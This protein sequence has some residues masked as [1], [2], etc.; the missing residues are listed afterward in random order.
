MSEFIS[1]E[2]GYSKAGAL[3]VVGIAATVGVAAIGMQFVGN[4]E[5][6]SPERGA[7]ADEPPTPAEPAFTGETL[8]GDNSTIAV[9]DAMGLYN[10]GGK[11]NETWEGK[12]FTPNHL[13]AHM[14][15]NEELR[16]SDRDFWVGLQ[17]TAAFEFAVTNAL[18]NKDADPNMEI[19]GEP[20]Y[21]EFLRKQIPMEG[22]A[23]AIADNHRCADTDNDK[24]PDTVQ[25][26]DFRKTKNATYTGLIL[27]KANFEKWQELVEE[28]G[29]EADR[30]IVT[31]FTH[32]L[33]G[34]G[35]D[36]DKEDYVHITN[37]HM[38]CA[39]NAT[40]VRVPEKTPGTTVTTAPPKLPPITIVIPT[41]TTTEKPTTTT[42]EKSTT[43]TT[44][45][46]TTTTYPH[47]TTTT[48]PKRPT[49]TPD[50]RPGSTTSTTQPYPTGTAGG[51]GTT[52]TTTEARHPSTTTTVAQDNGTPENPN[53]EFNG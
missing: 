46:T 3:T 18:A 15:A 27:T 26:H 5:S 50:P 7:G 47:Y 41:T 13:L 10:C 8:N 38:I 32:D 39:N 52:T 33:D 48:I 14:D 30:F 36:F 28:S 22:V 34:E 51:P 9:E 20:V 19:E 23:A 17:G 1:G 40:A 49:P 42:T 6:G 2:G 24:K 4:G 31:H 29:K 25:H 35:K 45:P 16:D 53:G 12:P 21:S 11:K 37:K 43:T 44:K